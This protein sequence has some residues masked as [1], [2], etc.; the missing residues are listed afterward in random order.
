MGFM[1]SILVTT[2]EL[3]CKGSYFEQSSIT[4]VTTD[5]SIGTLMVKEHVARRLNMFPFSLCIMYTVLA[6]IIIKQYFHYVN[7]CALQFYMYEHYGMLGH[8]LVVESENVCYLFPSH[9]LH[10]YNTVLSCCLCVLMAGFQCFMD[11]ETQKL[12]SIMGN[13]PV[14]LQYCTCED[15]QPL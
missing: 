11:K 6:V 7:K 1:L 3:K 5:C 4:S 15:W 14:C 13:I 12:C 8:G 9:L 2:L 10:R